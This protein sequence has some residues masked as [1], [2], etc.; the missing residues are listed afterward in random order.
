MNNI[1]TITDNDSLLDISVLIPIS[2]RVGDIEKIFV[3]HRKILDFNKLTYE[4]IF[5]LDGSFEKIE[6][7]LDFLQETNPGIVKVIKFNRHFGEARAINAAFVESTGE[8]ILT[9]PAYL[10][11]EPDNI[12]KLFDQFSEDID[13]LFAARYPR[14]DN[15]LNRIQSR[16][17]HGLVN[18]LMAESFKDISCGVRLMRRN[19]MQRIELYGDLYRFIPLLAIYKGFKVKEIYLQQAN[20]NF[21]LRLYGPGIYLTRFLDVFTLIFLIKFTQKP[22]R[23]F[24]AWGGGIAFIGALITGFTVY[25][26]LIVDISLSDRP[27]FL[28]GILLIMLGVQTF[29]IGLVA[30]IILFMNV[31]SEPHYNIEEK[32]E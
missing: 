1:S 18:S 29:F 30:E 20:D 6:K 17:F 8:K 22:L 11:I 5:V 23:F 9:L 12:Q 25:Q 4:F 10:Q 32:I 16:V 31:P 28:G 15:F 19:V 2:D 24:G 7:T 3:E 21:R 27:L 14:K 13:V 26:R